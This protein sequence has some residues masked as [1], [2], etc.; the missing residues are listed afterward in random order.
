MR[1]AG[2]AGGPNAHSTPSQPTVAESARAPVCW[3]T[4][5]ARGAGCHTRPCP[6]LRG[7]T[8]QSSPRTAGC[9][10]S[11]SRPRPHPWLLLALRWFT[12][13]PAQLLSCCALRVRER[14]CRQ[15]PR[16]VLC[17][18]WCRS[19]RRQPALPLTPPP[20]PAPLKPEVSSG[21]VHRA[22]RSPHTRTRRQLLLKSE[23]GESATAVPAATG[24]YS[25][26]TGAS[27]SRAGSP[28]VA[29]TLLYFITCNKVNMCA[30]LAHWPR[31]ESE[32]APGGN[33]QA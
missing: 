20:L 31:S 15:P 33:L 30:S 25:E 22:A 32:G 9:G 11:G 18:R 3:Q 23:R 12:P 10:G 29:N 5:L 4:C 1:V 6:P 24:A 27:M 28:T 17:C 14:C 21:Q 26:D 13:L 7:R 8:A 2:V 19:I 16:R